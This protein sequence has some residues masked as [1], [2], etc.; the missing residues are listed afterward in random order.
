MHLIQIIRSYLGVS[1]QELAR[2]V[3]IT[4]ADLCEMEIKPPYG[5]LD[6]YQRLSNYL[7][8]PIHALVTND[9]TLVPL[10]FFEKHPHAPYRKTPSRGSQ[11]LGRAGEEAALAYEH[12][13]LERVNPSLARLVI[14]HFKMGNRPGYDML[15]FTEK[16]EPIY[17]EVKT[18]ADDSP[19]YVLTNQEYLKANKAIANGE[20][21]LIYRFTNWGT[22]SQRMTI[23]DFR[24]QKENGEIWPSTFMCS[25]IS[26]VPVTTGIRF[27]REACGMS[28]SELAD[29]LGIQTCHLW[30]YETGEHQCPVDLYLRIS[31]ILGVEIDKLAEKYCTNNYS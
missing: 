3:G 24:E 7:G 22:D 2:R 11:V 29:Y 10:S 5:R 13:R 21:Y 9:S 30:R 26:K 18:S 1:Q 16:G 23:I 25:T 27:H 8:V 19:D 28:K 17:I 20:K 6:K 14:P 4:Q 15:S 12:M 31:E